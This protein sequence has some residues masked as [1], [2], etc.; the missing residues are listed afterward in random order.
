MIRLAPGAQVHLIG[1][2][3]TGMGALAGLLQEA[4]YT[5]TGSDAE[6]YPPV[7]T[8]LEE[9]KIQIK[10][11]YSSENLKNIPDMV[12]IGNAISRGN[13]E[14]ET[15]LDQGIPYTSMPEILRELFLNN[16]KTIVVA[17]THGKT[18]VTSM[19][20]WIFHSAGRSPGY[21]IGGIPSNFPYSFS[22]GTGGEFILEGD[23]YDTAFFDKG[24][25]FLHYRPDA[26]V[27]NPVEFDHA[28]IYADLDAVKTAFLRLV[29]LIPRKGILMVCAES[30]VAMECASKAF[31]K[32]E[33][34][35][36]NCGDWAA[37]EVRWEHGSGKFLVEFSGKNIG[38]LESTL[39]GDHNIKNF[40]GAAAMAS[41]CGI[42]W[43]QIQ[44]AARTF[45]GVRRRL[46]VIGEVA[47]VV[48]IDDFAH[49]PTA[50]RETLRAARKR[51]P[52]SRTWAL[53]EPRSN[54]LRRN[55]FEKELVQALALADHVVIADVYRK[56]KIPEVERLEPARVVSGLQALGI[57][58][59]LGSNAED[60]TQYLL[61]QLKSGDVIVVMSN[62]SF[63][64]IHQMIQD[65]LKSQ[66][67]LPIHSSL[68]SVEI[69]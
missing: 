14:L 29:N 37:R 18:T 67:L 44:H 64:G 65:R 68:P 47:G 24:P 66:K 39:A 59:E 15:V 50:V 27:L 5:V 53:L 62:G 9:L 41:R 22:A 25:K 13:Q 36:L 57:R 35:G 56:D 52:S 31:C 55:I 3:G 17:G 61:P 43:E 23:E 45:R 11:G 58:A 16:R 60:I 8:L 12:V 10:N 48:V 33:S 51:F 21:L 46:E 30:P 38:Y 42:A 4:G 26:V 32:V 34:F 54:T 2:A 1:I 63:G 20:A 19:L 7:S 69:V 49:H 28:D 40:L 6:I